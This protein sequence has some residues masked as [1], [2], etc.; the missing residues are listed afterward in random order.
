MLGM[1]CP[2]RKIQTHQT[3]LR[4]DLSTGKGAKIDGSSVS[5][6]APLLSSGSPETSTHV[7]SSECQC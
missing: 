5:L 1:W 7:P 6:H 3:V 2:V 4:V